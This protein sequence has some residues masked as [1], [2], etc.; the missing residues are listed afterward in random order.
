MADIFEDH[1][2]G[3]TSPAVSG[4]SVTPSDSLPL[5]QVTRALY[6]G[7]AG[8]LA[9]ELASGAQVTL[10]GV[11]GGA[12]QPLRVRRI[13]ATGTTASNLVALW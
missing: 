12:I 7:T 13:L 11:G 9:V 3:L 10:A 6:V 8:D 4:A 2:L 5:S 1:T